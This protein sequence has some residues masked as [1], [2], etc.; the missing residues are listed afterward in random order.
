M[1][2]SSEFLLLLTQGWNF[3]LYI[4]MRERERERER[5]RGKEGRT[6]VGVLINQKRD[7]SDDDNV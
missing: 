4:Y 1:F 7:I 6:T 2:V 3:T 5:E